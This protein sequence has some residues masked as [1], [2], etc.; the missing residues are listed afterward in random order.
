MSLHKELLAETNE[1]HFSSLA[2][3]HHKQ[4]QHLFPTP[5]PHLFTGYAMERF[6][7][8]R[9]AGAKYDVTVER[10]SATWKVSCD[11]SHRVVQRSGDAFTCT[12][13][14]MLASGIPC[15]HIVRVVEQHF[16]KEHF[17]QIMAKLFHTRWSL[18]VALSAMTLRQVFQYQVHVFVCKCV[19]HN[20][21]RSAA[22]LYSSRSGSSRD[23][24]QLNRWQMFLE[25]RSW[26]MN[27]SHSSTA[28]RMR[29]RCLVL[30]L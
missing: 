16:R 2:I 21:V 14:E 22:Y 20:V 29:R 13:I 7:K 15:R 18:A 8:E 5:L 23:H 1:E 6:N 4:G 30:K 28:P 26:R 12:C 11:G 3:M 19:S 24:E 10:A 27:A 25:V 17:N 9:I